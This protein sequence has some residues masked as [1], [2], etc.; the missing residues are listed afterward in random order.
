MNIGLRLAA[1]PSPCQGQQRFGF[2]R[3]QPPAPGGQRHVARP[4]KAA[5]ACDAVHHTKRDVSLGIVFTVGIEMMLNLG[6]SSHTEGLTPDLARAFEIFRNVPTP[7]A[8]YF[9]G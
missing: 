3:H 6:M 5:E 7:P 4:A 9:G 1:R 2:P 8:D